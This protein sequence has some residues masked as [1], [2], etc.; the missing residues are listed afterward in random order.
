MEMGKCNAQRQHK[1]NKE[2]NE[3]KRHLGDWPI[4]ATSKK[5]TFL[6]FEH[7]VSNRRNRN[8]LAS[9]IF[10]TTKYKFYIILPSK[11]YSLVAI[12]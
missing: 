6:P 12:S 2:M 8:V 5:L 4:F 3:N 9:Y 1:K 10:H 7:L 11:K